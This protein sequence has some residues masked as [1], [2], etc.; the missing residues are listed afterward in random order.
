MKRQTKRVWICFKCWNLWLMFIAYLCNVLMLKRNVCDFLCAVWMLLMIFLIFC[1]TFVERLNIG[2]WVI[3][4]SLSLSKVLELSNNILAS[5]WY[6]VLW[7]GAVVTNLYPNLVDQF[8]SYAKLIKIKDLTHHN[9]EYLV[10]SK[11][12]QPTCY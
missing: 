3:A 12:E 1:W 8:W 2:T 4:V 6:K 5:Y 11:K 7:Q 9:P 10:K